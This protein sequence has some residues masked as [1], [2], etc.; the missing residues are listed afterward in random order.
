MKYCPYCGAILPEVAVSFCPECG[1]TLP[2]ADAQVPE[3]KAPKKEKNPQKSKKPKKSK[4]QRQKKESEPPPLDDYDGYY[5]DRVPIDEG[6][7]RDGLDKSIIKK[8]VALAVG[9]LVVIMA[10]LAILYVL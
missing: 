8:V 1:E 3:E 7:R 2:G 5:N 9:L 10:C 6:R 4:P